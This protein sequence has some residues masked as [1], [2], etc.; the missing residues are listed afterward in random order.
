MSGIPKRYSSLEIYT[1]EM[2][3]PVRWKKFLKRVEKRAKEAR[4]QQ[5]DLERKHGKGEPENGILHETRQ[6][7][8]QMYQA[9]LRE[10]GGADRMENAYQNMYSQIPD[11]P[12]GPYG[13]PE[14]PSEGEEEAQLPLDFDEAED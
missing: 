14:A 9:I 10:N 2:K 1:E 11:W 5:E 7:F 6:Q 12:Y 13:V 8:L 4:K 3:D